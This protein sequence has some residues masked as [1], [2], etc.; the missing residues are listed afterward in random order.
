MTDLVGKYLNHYRIDALLGEGGMGAVYKAMHLTLD[1]PV[2]LKVMH[3]NFA[4]QHLFQQRFLQEAQMAAKLEHDSIIRVTD[5]GHA[6]GL[7][8][9]VMALI[10]GSTLSGYITE[11][12]K[13]NQVVSL[14]ETLLIMAQVADAL[15]Y[16]HRHEVVHRD[17]KPDNILIKHLELLP[18]A[19]DIPIRA[20]VTD[21]GLAKLMNNSM[22]S[23]TGSFL[24]TLPYMSPE[25]FT[26]DHIDGRSDI[27]SLGI[28]CFQLTTGRL[29]FSAK[30]PTDAAL[31]HLQD[32]I[33]L[34]HKINPNLPAS[35]EKIILKATAKRPFD[36]FQT[37][38]EIGDAFRYSANQI[39]RAELNEFNAPGA[40]FSLSAASLRHANQHHV[41]DHQSQSHQNDQLVI[42]AQ[43]KASQT[44]SLTQS[45]LSV[46]RTQECTIRL[47]AS[48]V[49]RRHAQIERTT[50]GWRIQDAGSANGTYLDNQKLS[51]NVPEAWQPGQMVRIGT[52][53]LK[54][55]PADGDHLPDKVNKINEERIIPTGA[56]QVISIPLN[57][58]VIINP[59]RVEILPGDE[60]TIQVEL[61]NKGSSM[62]QFIFA[63]DGLPA[64]WS[65]LSEDNVTLL[66][67]G[68]ATLSYAL[69]PPYSI[70]AVA[71]S[72]SYKLVVKSANDNLNQTTV[73]CQLVIPPITDITLKMTPASLENGGLCQIT[74]KNDGNSSTSLQLTGRDPAE[75]IHFDAEGTTI[76]LKPGQI[77]HV[78]VNIGVKQR[79]FIGHTHTIPFQFIAKT[80]H[81]IQEA[82]TG[83]LNVKPLLPNWLAAVLG[84]CLILLC[85]SSIWGYTAVSSK[86]K[87]T[88]AAE[89][90]VVSTIFAQANIN[91]TL[92]SE[93]TRRAESNFA[94]PTASASGA[95][96]QKP[97]FSE[98]C[99]TFTPSTVHLEENKGNWT[100][101]S[102]GGALLFT[103]QQSA[104]EAALKIMQHYGINEQ[105]FISRLSDTAPKYFLVN[106]HP[107][108]GAYAGEDC[109]A[110][111][112]QALAIVQN[113]GAWQINDGTFTIFN[114]E[115]NESDARLAFAVLNF[116]SF[117]H[118]CTV[119][120][121]NAAMIYFRQ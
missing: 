86:H 39:T 100:I 98:D 46:G 43:G 19:M 44:I 41:L 47:D 48:G 71:N 116:Y 60:S 2:A 7:Y 95:G 38:A 75:A 50:T 1:L 88:I 22:Q 17:I 74:I 33:P 25:Q 20:I 14:K 72:Y 82:V 58:E 52:Y 26:G 4:R 113:N 16:A 76:H 110:Y 109:A 11:M 56:A 112:T 70:H 107:P 108:N 53:F 8:Y 55:Q 29:P 49:S 32:P 67:N 12:M 66:P 81:G 105:C 97:P 31:K 83:Q 23:Q 37:A 65:T 35:V 102:D 118:V 89:T 77:E 121:P 24:G 92:E 54:W 3:A 10:S 103:S 13:N 64:N 15:A 57:L 96:Q 63:I 101:V 115:N 62:A 9:M 85:S 68:S 106:N 111:N 59:I 80:N 42:S 36:R 30:S 84:I 79:P 87:A 119:G 117:T 90:A 45:T 40:I 69:H 27:Y 28:M 21:F 51:P 91:A 120:Q 61:C 99:L 93:G 34:P 73:S 6:D 78:P 114:F 104:A 18:A 94:N 5:F